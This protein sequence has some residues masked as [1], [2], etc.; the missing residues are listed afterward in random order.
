[1]LATAEI[2]RQPSYSQSHPV[3][4]FLPVLLGQI[5][6]SISVLILFHIFAGFPRFQHS[7]CRQPRTDNQVGMHDEVMK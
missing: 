4:H 5:C 2:S 3:Y 6:I 1:M 7:E